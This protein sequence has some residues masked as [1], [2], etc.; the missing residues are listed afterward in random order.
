M[1]HSVSHVTYNSELIDERGSNL[2]PDENLLEVWVK[3]ATVK[4]VREGRE[5]GLVKF[6]VGSHIP[7]TLSYIHLYRR[8]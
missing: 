5:Q 4:E 3:S 1:A 6:G 7:L 2:N 8:E